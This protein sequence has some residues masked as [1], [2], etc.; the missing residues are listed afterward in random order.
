MALNSHKHKWLL[1]CLTSENFEHVLKNPVLLNCQ[2]RA[3]KECIEKN[4]G[5]SYCS[6]CSKIHD[7]KNDSTYIKDESFNMLMKESCLNQC[8]ELTKNQLWNRLNHVKSKFFS[9]AR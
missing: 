3:C 7:F 8:F 4:N 5:K 2:G 1:C 6:N 9:I